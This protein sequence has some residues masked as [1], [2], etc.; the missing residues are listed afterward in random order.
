VQLLILQSA[1]KSGHRVRHLRHSRPRRGPRHDPNHDALPGT[2][3]ALA[4]LHPVGRMGEVADI[5]DAVVFLEHAQFV[6]SEILHVI[7]RMRAG[8]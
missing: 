4:P 3:S 7:G 6:T 5:V 1:T 8:H 2:H